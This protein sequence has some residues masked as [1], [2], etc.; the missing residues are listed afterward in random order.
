MSEGL[1]RARPFRAHRPAVIFSSLLGTAGVAVAQQAPPTSVPQSATEAAAPTEGGGLEE[2][3]VTAQKRSESLQEVPLSVQALTADQ[4]QARGISSISSFMT[5]EVPSLRV[6]PFA[7]NQSIVEV[8]IRGFLDPN[9]SDITNENPVPVYIDDVYYGRQ[10][11]VALELN[12]L[13]RIEILRGPQG[14]LFGKNT[15]GGAVR[16]VSKD[17]TGKFDLS[18]RAEGGNFGYKKAVAHLNLPAIGNLSAKIDLLGT[19][20]NGYTT[21]FAPGQHDYGITQAFGGKLTLLYKPTDALSVEY[22]GDYTQMRTTEYWNAQISTTDPYH[23]VWPNQTSFP[24]TVP[25]Q[26]YRPY[27][28]QTYW[29]HRLTGSY[30][31]T[32]AVSVKS[33]TAFRVDQSTIYNTSANAAVVP[34]PFLSANFLKTGVCDLGPAIC[35]GLLTGTVP[36]YDIS[37]RQ[38]SEE[39]QL[40]GKT[41]DFEW[42]TGLFYIH[43][44]GSQ[45]ENTYFDTL[46]P[47]SLGGPASLGFFPLTPTTSSLLSSTSPGLFVQGSTAGADVTESSV[48]AFGQATWR[49]SAFE[50]KLALTAG[51]R[52]GR[53]K[54]DA[55]RPAP[56]QVYPEVTYPDIAGNFTPGLP[57][58]QSPQCSPSI[59]QTKASPMAAI[60]Y[61]LTDGVQTYF[62]FATGY[63]APGLSVGSQTFRYVD[64]STVQSY[65]LGIKSETLERTLRANL[66]AFYL[67]W[68]RP[69]ENVQTV[70]E[71]TVEFFSGPQINISGA[72]LE[73]TYQ[74]MQALRLDGELT[75]LHGHQ[76]A[77]SNPFPPPGT[78]GGIQVPLHIV[79]LP[80]WA[81]SLS[82]SYDLA[83][84]KYGTWRFSV[85]GNGT[86]SYF[87][88]PNAPAVD[89]YWL[90]NSRLSLLD[91]P[92][93][94]DNSSLEV[95]LWGRNLTDKSYRVFQY[96]TPGTA[97]GSF[98]VDAAYGV[99]RTYGASVTY[100]FD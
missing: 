85:Q 32:D 96:E 10:T 55:T 7:G 59:T 17:P 84:T 63:Q 99:P 72:E 60:G 33:I 75:V 57:C 23:S 19:D 82:A 73:L 22:A 36:V 89:G 41:G 4:L 65:E 88:V 39:L 35:G 90:L 2:I 91:I 86:A 13:E 54:K 51:V 74:P 21:N 77:I 50:K 43:E 69:Q 100:K 37:H 42:L 79:N 11:G 3:V 64:S 49:P 81:A 9:G 58:P 53:D 97:P 92:V 47:N 71:S 52:V 70:S 31:I 61:D 56:G 27:D 1:D 67:N 25:Y 26:T 30:A 38:F 80:D 48:A 8:G 78:L 28:P 15:E 66:A 93:G 14:T 95:S 34:G 68:N 87:T 12:D 16:M 18:V 24:D 29:G 62:R 46:L 5:G 40:T 98:N 44:K 94:G 6:E 76:P 20:N 83:R 45:I